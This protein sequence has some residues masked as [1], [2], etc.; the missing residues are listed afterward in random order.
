MKATRSKTPPL[1]L[2]WIQIE[3]SAKCNA[4]CAYC[5][6]SCYR[7]QWKGGLMD[8]DT[9]ERI[10]PNFS[11]ADLVFLQGWGEPLLHP[12]LWEMVERAKAAGAKVGFTTNATLLDKDKMKRIIDLDV[13]IVGVSMAGTH[14]AT[15]NRFRKGCDFDQV[16][17]NLVEL[18]RMKEAQSAT[19]PEMHIAFMLLRSNLGDLKD[20]PA[21]AARWGVKQIVV[22]NLTFVGS[23]GLEDE[24]LLLE[25]GL[26]GEVTDALES[27][28]RAAA[29]RGIELHYYG[30]G[31][32][33]PL[34]L[35]REN[36]LHACFV[37][38]RGDVTP[39]VMTGFSLSPDQPA[40][41][42]FKGEEYDIENLSFGNVRDHTLSDIWHSRHA[43]DFHQQYHQ[44]LVMYEP[45]TWDTPKP[46]RHCYKLIEQ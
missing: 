45:E 33:E 23:K 27:A 36:V 5:V 42:Y 9:F 13:D 32:G 16:D 43:R 17:R 20:L 31:I 2:D 37:T 28:K 38:Y 25:P 18:K 10:Q 3:V 24:C 26:W 6:L 1:A 34:A 29:K 14:A 8:M 7:D 40:K 30:P 35:C 41:H 39:C 22:S 4:S 11:S 46:C 19:A 44:R 21:L 12:Q 15:H